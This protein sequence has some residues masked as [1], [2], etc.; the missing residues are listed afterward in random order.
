MLP[1]NGRPEARV[2]V[3]QIAAAWV[4]TGH[5]IYMLPEQAILDRLWLPSAQI[6][7]SVVKFS[8]VFT[9]S[10][11]HQLDV[12]DVVLRYTPGEYNVQSRN[13][14]EFEVSSESNTVLFA[15]AFVSDC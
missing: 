11:W 2:P 6:Y 4:A 14:F 3:H 5:N 12:E 8:N 15:G 7:L 9:G 1:S 10:L 13:L